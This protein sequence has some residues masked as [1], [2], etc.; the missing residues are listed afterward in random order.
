MFF[1]STIF[2]GN[3]ES[4]P[5]FDSEPEPE[6]NSESKEREYLHQLKFEL[7]RHQ[8]MFRRQLDCERRFKCRRLMREFQ[9][10][11]Q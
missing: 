9:C 5:E 3:K 6:S 1:S 10:R 8:L 11:Q 7:E 4:E 2:Y